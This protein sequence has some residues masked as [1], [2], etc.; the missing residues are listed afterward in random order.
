MVFTTEG[1]FEVAKESCLCGIWTNVHWIPFRRFNTLSYN[2]ISSTHT[3][4][5]LCTAAPVSLF[6]Q[7]QISFRLLPS[8]V[9]TFILTEI[10]LS[11]YYI[12]IIYY[13]HY[14]LYILYI[15]IIYINTYIHIDRY[16]DIYYI[17]SN[18]FI[19]IFLFVNATGP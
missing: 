17:C 3:E 1:F 6:V 4:N 16:I 11:Y 2:A 18:F 10:S 12:Y 8:S 7:C 5:Q 13:I 9:A 14:T 15:Y 19:R